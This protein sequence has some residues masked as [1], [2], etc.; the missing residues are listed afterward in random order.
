MFTIK[1]K[2]KIHLIIR[3]RVIYIQTT[4]SGYDN[5]QRNLRMLRTSFLILYRY[6]I[7]ILYKFIKQIE[8]TPDM[9]L[10]SGS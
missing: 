7:Y 9:F 4:L 10:Y 6:Y 8:E 1:A 2:E 3:K 5:S